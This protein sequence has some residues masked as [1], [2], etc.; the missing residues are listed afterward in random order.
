MSNTS[1]LSKI[2]AA[3]KLEHKLHYA[4][5]YCKQAGVH[6]SRNVEHRISWP[7]SVATMI[8]AHGRQGKRSQAIKKIDAIHIVCMYLAYKGGEV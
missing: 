1:A 6:Y 3:E 2:A 4:W 5:E 8:H 7:E